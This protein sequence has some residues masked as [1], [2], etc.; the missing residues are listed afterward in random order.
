MKLLD[1]VEKL[2]LGTFIKKI[3]ETKPHDMRIDVD[4]VGEADKL[5]KGISPPDASAELKK[6]LES[7]LQ[8]FVARKYLQS[9]LRK[10][11]NGPVV[12]KNMID[13]LKLALPTS[14]K[15]AIAGGGNNTTSATNNKNVNSFKI[16][17]E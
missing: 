6:R 16:S 1:T 5:D 3:H 12:D 4:R 13:Q 14:S 2:N 8:L 9:S 11:D 17:S 7:I 15:N 10:N